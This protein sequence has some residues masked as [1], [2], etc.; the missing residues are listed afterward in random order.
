[1]LTDILQRV[2]SAQH[3]TNSGLLHLKCTDRSRLCG[4][5]SEWHMATFS[6]PC[7]RVLS[8]LSNSNEYHQTLHLTKSCAG[9]ASISVEDDFTRRFL[10]SN[11]RGGRSKGAF[12]HLLVR[13]AY[14]G[15]LN[16]P[17]SVSSTPTSR[18]PRVESPAIHAKVLPQ[19]LFTTRRS[20]RTT[21]ILRITGIRKYTSAVTAGYYLV[22]TSTFLPGWTY[23]FLALGK[24]RGNPQRTTYKSQVVKPSRRA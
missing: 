10:H 13:A 4:N 17:V 23:S 15:S 3:F 2:Q 11:K 12:A 7:K 16:G 21:T 20:W 18:R 14:D 9:R 1:M 24:V 5:S 22:K 8:S 19:H 6:W